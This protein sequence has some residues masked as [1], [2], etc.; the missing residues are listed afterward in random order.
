M[1][2]IIQPLREELE[3]LYLETKTLALKEHRTSSEEQTLSWDRMTLKRFTNTLKMC[4]SEI[5][6]IKGVYFNGRN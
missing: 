2:Q 6:K 5:E 3:K 1:Q 4:E